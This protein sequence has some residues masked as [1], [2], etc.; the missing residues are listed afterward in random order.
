MPRRRAAEAG[1]PVTA[2]TEEAQPRRR[3]NLAELD[4]WMSG[5]DQLLA[6]AADTRTEAKKINPIKAVLKERGER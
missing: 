5:V 3:T 1:E 2:T 4:A 6:E